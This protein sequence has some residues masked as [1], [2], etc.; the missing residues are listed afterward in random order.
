MIGQKI[1]NYNVEELLGEGGMGTVYR[2]TDTLLQRSVAVKILHPHLVRDTT[3]FE[4]FRNEAILSAKLNHSNVAVLYNFLRDRNDNFMVM[5]YIDGMTLEKLL[6]QNGGLPLESVLKIMMQ[7]L[8][9]LHHAH[10][11]G[12]LHRD[13]KPANLM[14]TRDGIV[15]LMDFGIARMVGSQRLTRADRIVGTLEYMAPEL[16]DGSEPGVQSD[17]YAIGVLM[18]ELLSGKMPFEASTDSTLITQ[19]LT[20]KPIP[21]RSRI[22]NLPKKVEEILDTLLQKK[23]EKRFE[24]AA[25]LRYLLSTIV[26]P[27]KVIPQ[28]LQPKKVEVNIAPTEMYTKANTNPTRLAEHQQQ[29]KTGSKPTVVQ[30]VKSSMLS[31]EG[32]ILGGA[33]LVAIMIVI[34]GVFFM[35]PEKPDKQEQSFTPTTE[36]VIPQ[37]V[38][39][40]DSQKVSNQDIGFQQPLDKVVNPTEKKETKPIN[41]P[42]TDNKEK[43]KE[44]DKG[45]QPIEKKEEEKK[46]EEPKPSPTEPIVK[47]PVTEPVKEPE[48]VREEPKAKHTQ[49]V[50][51]RGLSVAVVLD[52][53]I[54]SNDPGIRGKSIN[55]RVLNDIRVDGIVVIAAGARATGKVTSARSS[56]AGKSFLEFRPERVQAVNGDW[57]PLRSPDLGKSGSSTEPVVFTRGMRILPDPKT[58]NAIL[59]ITL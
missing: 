10:E 39:N 58:A 14:L 52:E 8:D 44:K 29:R 15:K 7:T 1:Q 54:S 11:K 56:D 51:I 42:P 18:Y 46:K 2:A 35:S 53:T 32:M 21:L 17:L 5:E 38:A 13:I 47:Q 41:I 43:G 28:T 20:K 57:V 34:G 22:G 55:L 19:I 40:T 9:G 24:S 31:T 26:T 6:K 49:N 37:T 23:P 4:R 59:T 48:P 50:S 45:K 27:G 30:T 33:V 25:D 12:I 36:V 3:F 16:L